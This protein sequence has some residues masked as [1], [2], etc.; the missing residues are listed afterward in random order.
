VGI[1]NDKSVAGMPIFLEMG[2]RLPRCYSTSFQFTV[3]E[4]LAIA[5]MATCV[6]VGAE[7]H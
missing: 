5:L 6:L 1:G 7:G 4:K 2:T 3:V